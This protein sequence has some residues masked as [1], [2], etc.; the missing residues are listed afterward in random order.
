MRVGFTGGTLARSDPLRHDAAALFRAAA[1][2]AARLLVLDGLTPAGDAEGRLQ[3]R[4]LDGAS[5]ESLLLLG[6]DAEGR[7]HFAVLPSGGSDDGGQAMRAPALMA[8]LDALA[9]GEA[10][11][12]AAARSLILWHARHRFCA[13]CGAAA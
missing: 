9:P 2:P 5:A 6:R 1:A 7:A 8:M 3:W 10:A 13:N 11:T 12:Y 4:P